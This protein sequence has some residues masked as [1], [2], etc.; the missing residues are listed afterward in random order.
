MGSNF[1]F[2]WGAQREVELNLWERGV[3]AR[4]QRKELGSNCGEPNAKANSISGNR[5]VV[6]R[7]TEQTFW[8][9][10]WGTQRDLELNQWYNG[11]CDNAGTY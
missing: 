1:G 9:K 10:L 5:D 4:Q 2:L 11:F 7:C 6:A 3:V 8:L